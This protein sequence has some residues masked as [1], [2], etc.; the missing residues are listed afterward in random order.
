ML[1]PD[2]RGRRAALALALLSLLASVGCQRAVDRRAGAPAVLEKPGPVLVEPVHSDTEDGVASDDA[3]DPRTDD[4]SELSEAAAVSASDEQVEPSTSS[5]SAV[6]GPY[7]TPLDERET[8][9][10]RVAAR[11]VSLSPAQCRAELQR[12]K[13][14]IAHAGGST[15]G[16]ATPVRL[17]GDLEGVRFLTPGRK[18]VFGVLD[19]RLSLVLAELAKLL[20]EHSVAAIHIDNMYRPQAHL[21]GSK[22]KSQHAYGLAVDIYGFTLRDGTTLVVE[23]DFHRTLGAPPCGPDAALPLDDDGRALALRNIFCAIARARQFNYLLTPNYDESHR[24][25]IHADVQRKTT[26]HVVR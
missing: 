17:S 25:H 15:P 21:P 8:P 1:S 6:E 23:R 13:L 11:L 19:C 12:R 16:V 2:P 24:D 26:A 14:A 5:A 4:E 20:A 22:K 18:S 10:Q 7:R 9:A 3:S